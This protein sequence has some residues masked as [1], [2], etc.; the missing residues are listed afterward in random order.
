[1]ELAKGSKDAKV[2]KDRA[3]RLLDDVE[4]IR[5]TRANL[6]RLEESTGQ[7]RKELAASAK[8]NETLRTRARALRTAIATRRTNLLSARTITPQSYAPRLA[9]S[10]I[11]FPESGSDWIGNIDDINHRLAHTRGSLV[12]ELLE[13]F[14]LGETAVPTIKSGTVSGQLP[15]TIA[16]AWSAS[17][18][19]RHASRF[20]ADLFLRPSISTTKKPLEPPIL[21]WTI[22]G[23]VLPL[24]S[25]VQ[26]SL[27]EGLALATL[28]KTN[29]AIIYTLHF[30]RVLCFY[31]GVKLPFE[32][33]W[34]G[35]QDSVGI[36]Y[37]KAGPGPANGNWAKWT[38]PCALYLRQS[39][40]S[41]TPRASVS[42]DAYC[43]AYAMLAYNV[44]YLAYTQSMFIPLSQS[45]NIL[46]NLWTLCSDDKTIGRFSHQSSSSSYDASKPSAVWA[47]VTA[48]GFGTSH[49]VHHD[50]ILAPPTPVEFPLDFE[51][52]LEGLAGKKIQPPSESAA[53]GE[54]IIE[55]DG[56]VIT[57]NAFDFD[58]DIR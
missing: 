46:A 36:P 57:D 42:I 19:G 24:P 32:V 37:L 55:E 20:G 23:L 47:P 1:M 35:K 52:M 34:S 54:A 51:E 10:A 39:L 33:W 50:R 49:P 43:I 56:W 18:L 5:L 25:D 48:S 12:E 38:V 11:L 8:R 14:D 9:K 30:V 4:P 21:K 13:A 53:V 28:E 7:L 58:M 2:W 22:C 29:A 44:S 6:K 31:L 17:G 3:Q 16:G 26:K 40:A 41:E 27:Q 15:S 45:A